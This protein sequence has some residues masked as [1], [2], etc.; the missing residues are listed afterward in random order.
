MLP[1]SNDF[2]KWLEQKA[3]GAKNDLRESGSA[4]SVVP[5]SRGRFLEEFLQDRSELSCHGWFNGF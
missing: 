4:E 2:F 1:I 5:K 3:A